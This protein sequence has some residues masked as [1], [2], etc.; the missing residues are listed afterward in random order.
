MSL[1]AVL[2]GLLAA[3][4]LVRRRVIGRST[5]SGATA[6]PLVVPYIAL[7]IGSPRVLQRGENPASAQHDRHGPR[8]LTIPYTILVLVPRLER[9]DVRLEEAARDLGAG[10]GPD[11]PPDH[12]PALLPADRSAYMVAFVLSFDEV[13]MASFVD[14]ET[15]TFPLYL[16]SQSASRRCS[17]R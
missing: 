7:A 14:G 6:E 9:L 13:V 15:T 11:L 2:L 10:P 5:A 1:I 17:R 4:V 16:L 8:R 3:V 12:A